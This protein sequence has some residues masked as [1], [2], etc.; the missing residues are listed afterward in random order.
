V[1]AM[2][3]TAKS[4]VLV[5]VV[6]SVLLAALVAGVGNFPQHRTGPCQPGEEIDK[7]MGGLHIH[8][9]YSNSARLNKFISAGNIRF[10]IEYLGVTYELT[11]KPPPPH[12][13]N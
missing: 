1:I 3:T 10:Y 13:L 11:I 12:V 8:R 5:G 9:D 2:N 4:F 6:M 7:D